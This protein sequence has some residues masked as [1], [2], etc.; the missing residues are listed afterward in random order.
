MSVGQPKSAGCKRNHIHEER[1]DAEIVNGS[2][3][4]CI[5]D[6][7]IRLGKH[8]RKGEKPEP[9]IGADCNKKDHKVGNHIDLSGIGNQRLDV[10]E[11][12]NQVAYVFDVVQANTNDEQGLHLADVG[13]ACGK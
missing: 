4:A 8:A 13:R 5:L 7:D 11:E 2:E 6:I 10:A 12:D 3:F 9:E 1:E